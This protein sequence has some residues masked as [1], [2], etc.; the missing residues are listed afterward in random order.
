MK[1]KKKS[2]DLKKIQDDLENVSKIK[3]ERT[4]LTNH[5]NLAD[6]IAKKSDY[7]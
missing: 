6:F 5:I 3:E 7:L 2:R 1:Q 4:S